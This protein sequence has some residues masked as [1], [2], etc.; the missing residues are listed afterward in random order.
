MNNGDGDIL[1]M[2]RKIME[3]DRYK[4][5]NEDTDDPVEQRVQE[6]R[7]DPNDIYNAYRD[8]TKAHERVSEE[9]LNVQD[10]PLKVVCRRAFCPECGKEVNTKEPLIHDR[11]TGETYVRYTCTC[12][13]KMRF[14]HQYP[15]V[16]FMDDN[17]EEFTPQ[18]E[19]K[20]EW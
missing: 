8:A 12:G 3:E 10:T 4:P 18:G 13:K 5:L 2:Y 1:G 9:K 15:R 11:F 20:W 14:S 7:N 17:N 16:V 19:K 6:I